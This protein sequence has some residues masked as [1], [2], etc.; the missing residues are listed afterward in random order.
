[1]DHKTELAAVVPLIRI[2]KGL[3]V[4]LDSDLARLYGVTTARLNQQ[5]RRNP[6]KF[7]PDFAFVLT[8]EQALRM[9]SQNGDG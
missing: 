9:L 4:I 1:M 5:F 2:V 3:R 6:G 7:P 8:P